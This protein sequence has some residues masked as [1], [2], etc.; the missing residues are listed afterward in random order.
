MLIPNL[1]LHQHAAVLAALTRVTGLDEESALTAAFM[2]ADKGRAALLD[3]LRAIRQASYRA[4]ANGNREHAAR[5]AETTGRRVVLDLAAEHHLPVDIAGIILGAAI[6]LRL[7][8][9]RVRRSGGHQDDRSVNLKKRHGRD[10]TAAEE[11]TIARQWAKDMG[12]LAR[13]LPGD[14]VRKGAA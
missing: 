13:R 4:T 11:A 3:P 12:K 10:V 1:T 14:P 9:A 6:G 7:G 8:R 2:D 5:V